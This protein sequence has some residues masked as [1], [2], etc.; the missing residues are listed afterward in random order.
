MLA[1]TVK[2]LF[3]WEKLLNFKFNKTI[4]ILGERDTLSYEDALA[5]EVIHVQRKFPKRDAMKEL[6]FIVDHMPPGTNQ[7]ED[8][9]VII[10]MIYQPGY[11][12]ETKRKYYQNV[13]PFIK[14][15]SWIYFLNKNLYIK[16]RKE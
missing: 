16:K 9:K 3:D 8:R 12:E 11:Y 6:E 10:K 2:F 5:L 13:F 4:R 7:E 14:R 15:T 1:K